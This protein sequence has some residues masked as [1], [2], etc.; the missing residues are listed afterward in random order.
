VEVGGVECNKLFELDAFDAEP[1][2]QVG[3]D[4]RIGLD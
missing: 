3:E 1:L 4:A 2:E